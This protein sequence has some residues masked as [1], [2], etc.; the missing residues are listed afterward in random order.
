MHAPSAGKSHRRNDILSK[1]FTVVQARQFKSDIQAYLYI[2][3]KLPIAG[4]VGTRIHFF[5]L[6]VFQC[7]PQFDEHVL[8]RKINIHHKNICRRIWAKLGRVAVEMFH[9]VQ[10]RPKPT[11]AD[12]RA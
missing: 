3:K 7:G 5:P 9:G 1:V 6:S 2:H 8:L 10:Q 11:D 12:V 4:Q